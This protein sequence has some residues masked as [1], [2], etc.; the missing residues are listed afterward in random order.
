MKK[1]LV[2]LSTYNGSKY[3]KYQLD[4]LLAQ[5]GV[6]VDIL[7]RDDHSTDATIE[8]LHRYNIN[9]YTGPNLGAAKSFLDLIKKANAEYRAYDY[10]A[11]SDQDDQWKENK[12]YSAVKALAKFNA[13]L[14]CGSTNA[15]DEQ[16]HISHIIPA[17]EYSPIETLFRNSVAGC[18]MVFDYKVVER[19]SEY[20]PKWLEMHDSWILR[21]CS[22]CNDLKVIYD[23]N[24]YMTYRLHG[25][26]TLGTSVGQLNRITAHLKNLFYTDKSFISKTAHELLI[27]YQRYFDNETKN[28]LLLFDKTSNVAGRRKKI[29]SLLM[30]N[31]FSTSKRKFD[32]VFYFL[33]RKA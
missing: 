9:Y 18:T 5:N 2:L 33:F 32:Y 28:M 11:F 24:P 22:Y 21:V 8:I 16:K 4:S 31:K 25:D 17:T 30:K 3:L 6:D 10:Y 14:Y 29:L 7:V 15:Y 13:N 19:V 26:N 27:G 20:Q 1:V 12:L 23:K